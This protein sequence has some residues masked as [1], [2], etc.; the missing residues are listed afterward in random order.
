MC[1]IYSCIES[2][3]LKRKSVNK[4]I[5]ERKN[6]MQETVDNQRWV[7]APTSTPSF[8][9]SAG[10]SPGGPIVSGGLKNLSLSKTFEV[11]TSSK[12]LKVSP[13]RGT[14]EESRRNYS[15]HKSSS[16]PRSPV[17][18]T[19]PRIEDDVS[20]SWI[21]ISSHKYRARVESSTIAAYTGAENVMA[22]SDLRTYLLSQV[23]HSSGRVENDDNFQQYLEGTTN[24]LG[25]P[26]S[27][28]TQ[29]MDREFVKDIPIEIFTR[30]KSWTP[31]PSEGSIPVQAQES[32]ITGSY[33]KV[34]I[35]VKISS[36]AYYDDFFSSEEDVRTAQEND[37]ISSNLVINWNMRSE[38]EPSRTSNSI[39]FP[40]T[41]IEK[42]QKDTK[43]H[44]QIFVQDRADGDQLKV[45][46]HDR[47]LTLESVII[48]ENPK[49]GTQVP[50]NKL[51][52]CLRKMG[53]DY[54]SQPLYDEIFS[55]D[56][57]YLLNLRKSGSQIDNSVRNVILN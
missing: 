5:S 34:K 11:S 23:T 12:K 36:P 8:K 22:P 45:K 37:S 43:D 49:I 55:E 35:P 31:N 16:R 33:K 14:S 57:S 47:K 27:S 25:S 53:E 9:S 4:S 6:E 29:T 30:N 50:D 42:N 41:N 18:L 24:N 7:L 2:K 54:K 48:L 32:S 28:H 39:T 46:H 15:S 17:T 21:S 52:G 56:S 44:P 13:R 51:N 10:N 20:T 26:E 3:L 19:I 38:V 40:K 1:I